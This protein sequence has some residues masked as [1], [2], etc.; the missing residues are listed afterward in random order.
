MSTS[1][2]GRGDL[3][4]PGDFLGTAEEFVPG[5]GTYE[6]NGRVYAALFG[7]TQVDPQA[8]AISVRALNAIPRIAEGDL[9]Y[10]RVDEIKSAMAICTILASAQTNRSVPGAPEGTVHI[11]KARD[12]Y[13]ESLQTEFG[14]GDIVLAKVLQ[15]RPTIKLTTAPSALGVV[16]ARCQNC[17]GQLTLDGKGGLRCPRCGE[18]ERRKLSADY[19]SLHTKLAGVHGP[20][21][22]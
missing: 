4:L 8:R 14:V 20:S 11:S 15:G 18:V 12:G 2:H 16:A 9:V 13:T 7:H 19:G 3:V 6:D 17:H 1:T 5:Q 10:A 22:H 21:A